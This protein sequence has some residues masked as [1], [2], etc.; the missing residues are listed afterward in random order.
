[1]DVSRLTQG[2]D[3]LAVVTVMNPSL[4]R[5]KDMALTQIFPSGWEIRNTRLFDF[6]SSQ[7]ISVPNYQDFRDDRVLTYFDLSRGQSKTF[8]IPLNASYLGRFYLPGVYCEA[9]YDN[10]INAVQ[11]GKW[12]EVVIP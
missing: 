4:L 3:F 2:S 11:E 8:V 5:Y 6:K 12:I 7:E 10:S 1:M 9:M